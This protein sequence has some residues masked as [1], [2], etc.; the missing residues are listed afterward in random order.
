MKEKSIDKATTRKE[1]RA[2]KEFAREVI[3]YCLPD[4]DIRKRCCEFLAN[5]IYLANQLVPTR[6]G[7][8]LYSDVVLMN[9]GMIEVLQILPDQVHVIADNDTLPEL[10]PNQV[11]IRKTPDGSTK[12]FYPSV[13]GS[14]ACD[15][16]AEKSHEI[17][18]LIEESHKQLI[19]KASRTSFAPN[20]KNAH[21]PGVIEWLNEYLGLSL[22]QP[23]YLSSTSE[24]AE[25][26]IPEELTPSE[27]YSE[28]AA[29]QIL[30][31]AYERDPKARAKCITNYGTRCAVC[32]MS[33]EERY[34]SVGK[35]FIHV[36]HL[37]PLSLIGESS[38][39]DPIKDLRPVCANCHAIIHRKNPP[40]S[41]EEVAQMIEATSRKLPENQ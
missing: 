36:H 8:T 6:W 17:L 35:D 23:A 30:V 3:E 31:N 24:A 20:R 10:S 25:G 13:S 16:V 32:R 18:L 1:L 26:Y 29:K 19:Q 37:T 15:F 40:Y 11:D 38:L 7:I 22:P 9:C 27:K 5:S 28:G 41:I 33:F 2:D 39:V 12:G 21:S 4:E 14:V 34:G